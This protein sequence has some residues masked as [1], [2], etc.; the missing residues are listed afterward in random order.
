ML[1]LSYQSA[2]EYEVPFDYERIKNW[3]IPETRQRY[4]DRDTILYAL[5]VGA[6]T[7]NPLVPEDLQYVY[8]KGL[9]ALPTMATVLAGGAGW[10]AD[11]ETGIDLTK[12]LH[13][14]QF[15]TV[16]S[17]LPANGEVIGHDRV[18]EIY[19][20]GADKGAVMYMSRQIFCAQTNT[21]LATSTWST[22]MRGNGGF[23][24]TATGQPKPYAIPTDRPCDLSIEL[25]SRPEQAVIYRLSGDLNPLHIDPAF[26]AMAGFDKPILHGMSSYGM[27]GR[28][29]LKLLCHDDPNRLRVLNL[30]FAAPMYPGETLR[31]EVWHQSAGQACFRVLATQ[32]NITILNNGY[33][34]FDASLPIGKP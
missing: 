23:G 5:G 10:L 28:A 18:D 29:V 3:P 34:E 26:A 7:S 13:G 4:T 1:C 21:L 30:R 11:P 9:K 33:V 2:E 15:L 25:D 32:R 31:I 8:E 16:H 12:V 19:D 14:E 17:P 24:G 22:F 27:A 20:K 6:A